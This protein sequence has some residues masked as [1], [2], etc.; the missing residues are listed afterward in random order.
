MAAQNK[1]VLIVYAHHYDKSLNAAVLDTTTKA[2]KA[3]G[4][5]VIVSDLYAENFNPVL[6]FHDVKGE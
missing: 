5:D 6:G 3:D 1:T 4:C 2:L